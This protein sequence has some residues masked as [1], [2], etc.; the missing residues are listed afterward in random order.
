MTFLIIISKTTWFSSLVVKMTSFDQFGVCAFVFPNTPILLLHRS[1]Q[2]HI[3]LVSMVPEL[4]S[5]GLTLIEEMVKRA[6]G[7]IVYLHPIVDV[8]PSMWLGAGP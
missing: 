8:Q 5:V 6:L 7:R 1:V 4:E 3:D 2:D